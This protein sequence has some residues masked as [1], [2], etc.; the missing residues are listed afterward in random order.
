MT[1][2]KMAIQQGSGR[3]PLIGNGKQ[4]KGKTGE[5]EIKDAFI[6]VMKLVEAENWL[7][8]VSEK[9]KRN[10]LQSD[11]GGEDLVGIPLLSV[12][13]KRQETLSI[14]GWWRQTKGQADKSKLMPVLMYRQNHKSWHVVTYAQLWHPGY[15]ANLWVRADFSLPE[16]MEWYKALYRE[17]LTANPQSAL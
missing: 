13:V 15:Q 3:M 6:S 5:R 10:T 17:W 2:S 1:T 7:T 8:G 11:R 14:E 12:E 4:I 9:V 16:F